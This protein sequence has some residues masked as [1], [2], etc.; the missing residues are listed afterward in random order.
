MVS[1]HV[2]E[3]ESALIH[4]SCMEIDISKAT[5]SAGVVHSRAWLLGFAASSVGPGTLE[6]GHAIA[7]PLV[8]TK[9]P[10]PRTL[11][12]REG[13]AW[14]WRGLWFSVEREWHNT[15]YISSQGWTL[16]WKPLECVAVCT[17]IQCQAVFSLSLYLHFPLV[18]GN[19]TN[20]V[21]P[22]T[23]V[24]GWTMPYMQRL[25]CASPTGLISLIPC[26]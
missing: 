14:K 6:L 13:S 20:A 19:Y 22:L 25:T 23:S 1:V 15:K 7:L 9:H 4:R 18:K 26:S 16:W 8:I 2:G 5:V 10:E 12:G 11:Q 21:L 3:L 24:W 17:S